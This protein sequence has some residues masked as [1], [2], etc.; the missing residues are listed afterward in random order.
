MNEYSL[1]IRVYIEDTDAGGIVFYANYLKYF[2][3][4]RTELVRASGYQLRAGMEQNINY[5]VHSLDIRY[6]K[7]AR[8]DDELVVHAKV[9]KISKTYFQVRQWATNAEA[10]VLVEGNVKVACVEFDTGKPRKMP[11]ALVEALAE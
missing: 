2:E 10:E 1:P 5:V 11:A 6:I 7:P 3:R 4:V 9:V 8:L